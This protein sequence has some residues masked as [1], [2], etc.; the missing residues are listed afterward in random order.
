MDL[1]VRVSQ[2]SRA[3]RAQVGAVLV[4]PSKQHILFG[5]NGTPPKEANRC[6]FMDGESLS[7]KASVRHAEEN[8][9]I[10]SMGDDKWRGSELYITTLPCYDCA[11]NFLLPMGIT[12]VVFTNSYRSIAGA[13]ELEKNGVDVEHFDQPEYF[14]ELLNAKK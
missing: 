5:W 6:E 13:R 4:D 9:Y 7:T 3:I 2:Q 10:K 8:I 11:V 14:K 12:R 1:A